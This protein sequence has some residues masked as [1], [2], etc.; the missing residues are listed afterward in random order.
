MKGKTILLIDGFDLLSPTN[1]FFPYEEISNFVFEYSNCRFVISSRPGFFESIRT[2]FKVSELE[3]LTDDKIAIFIDKY[4]LNS[5]TA[6]LLKNKIFNNQQLESLLT[7]PMILYIAIKVAI[8]RKD[9]IED[10]LPSNRSEMYKAFV[11]GLFAHCITK[12]KTLCADQVQIKNAL[13]DFYFKLQCWNKVSCEYSKALDI[14]NKH[15]KDSR[16]KETS[17]QCI[18]E[19]CFKLGLLV[20]KGSEM[21]DEKIEYGIHQSF[22]EYFAAMKLKELFEKGFDI[23]EAFS[24]PKWEEVVIFT[25]EMLDPVDEF[26]Y[27][28]LPKEDQKQRSQYELF[29][30]SKCINKASNE[31]KEKL[32]VL[33]ANKIDCRYKSEKI[34]S[35]ESLGRIGATGSSVG[36]SLIGV[37]VEALIDNDWLVRYS[38]IKALKEIKSEKAVQSL[39]DLLQEISLKKSENGLLKDEDYYLQYSAIKALGKIK[40]EKAM[41]P[42]IGLLNE[43]CT[44]VNDAAREALINIDS[45]KAIKMLIDALGDKDWSIRFGAVKA[46]GEVKSEKAVQMLI[47]AL[48][49][50]D[51]NILV[52]RFLINSSFF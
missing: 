13:T 19:D 5:K 27:L 24:H 20:K 29:L 49:D 41:K 22:Q 18:L 50:K 1:E 30:A 17:A 32:S 9:N 43:K 3:K 8:E 2:D 51:S 25:A 52:H 11:S 33:L 45:E 42:L 23:S 10:L 37:L 36:D 15:A 46:L 40:S 16:F 38:T 26:I 12:G 44:N 31:T 4:V 28:M 48:R 6:D 35:I 39:I 34:K 47:D 21:E 7:N 14:V